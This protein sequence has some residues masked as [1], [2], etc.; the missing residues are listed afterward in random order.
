MSDQL[1]V[2]LFADFYIV[3]VYFKVG[4]PTRHELQTQQGFGD[5]AGREV[6]NASFLCVC[7]LLF[8]PFL[9][10]KLKISIL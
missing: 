1:R 5:T 4:D 8:L 10:L 2:S 3:H 7:V 9:Y 6:E